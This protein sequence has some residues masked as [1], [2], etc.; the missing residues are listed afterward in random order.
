MRKRWG[1]GREGD[2]RDAEEEATVTEERTCKKK[3]K[4]KGEYMR[5]IERYKQKKTTVSKDW[6]FRNRIYIIPGQTGIDPV[7]SGICQHILHQAIPWHMK[8]SL[9]HNI[10]LTENWF[11]STGLSSHIPGNSCQRWKSPL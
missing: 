5:E 4:I 11:A 10:R 6:S 3:S 7:H 8:C 1:Y 2:D 9:K